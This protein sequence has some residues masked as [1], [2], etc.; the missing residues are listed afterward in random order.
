MGDHADDAYEHAENDWF[1]GLTG[2]GELE[3]PGSALYARNWSP[4]RAVRVPSP[5]LDDLDRRCGES[6]SEA[7]GNAEGAGMSQVG[8]E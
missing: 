2:D 1:A 6:H 3:F 7:S 4:R 5:S 8:S